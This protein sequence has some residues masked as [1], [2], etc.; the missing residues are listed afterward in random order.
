MDPE[1]G[2]QSAIITD[3]NAIRD[4]RIKKGTYVV[5]GI[6][7]LGTFIGHAVTI[8]LGVPMFAHCYNVALVV[9]IIGSVLGYLQ[10]KLYG[11]TFYYKISLEVQLKIEAI[12]IVVSSAFDFFMALWVVS[13]LK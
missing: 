12:E 7:F 9:M 2:S 13:E 6:F 8:A 5:A 11:E 4:E 10:V 1:F 3:E